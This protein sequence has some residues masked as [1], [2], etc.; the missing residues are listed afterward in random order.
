MASNKEYESIASRTRSKMMYS[1]VNPDAMLQR[2][3]TPHTKDENT[4]PD[5]T[6]KRVYESDSRNDYMY[7]TKNQPRPL[8]LTTRSDGRQYMYDTM[9]Q[10]RQLAW[11]TRSDGRQYMYDTMNQPSQLDLTTRSD[12]RQYQQS[13]KDQ[14]HEKSV[15]EIQE[16]VRKMEEELSFAK[17]RVRRA[18]QNQEQKDEV[19][20]EDSV[21]NVSLNSSSSTSSVQKAKVKEIE[22]AAKMAN[23]R[24]SNE[25]KERKRQLQR[26]LQEVVM[27]QELEAAA[28]RTREELRLSQ[29]R[30]DE[31]KMRQEIE[32]EEERLSCIEL[33]MAV[34]T[35]YEAAIA[36]SRALGN[37]E[38][39]S[40][41]AIIEYSSCIQVD[42]INSIHQA[43]NKDRY[44]TVT[45]PPQYTYATDMHSMP[46]AEDGFM[47]RP[48]T[49]TQGLE[50][51][52]DAIQRQPDTTEEKKPEITK[53]KTSLMKKASASEVPSTA[54]HPSQPP[55]NLTQILSKLAEQQRE[56]SLPKPELD[57]FNGTDI[58]AFPT[59]MRN[60]K[61]VVEDKTNDDIRR[62]ELLLKYTSGEARQLIEQCPMIE[63][64]EA[65]YARA[66]YLL[67]RDYGQSTILAAA[68]RSKAEGWP[69]VAASDKEAL[70]RYSVFL[71]NLCSGKISNPDL[72][73]M[74]QL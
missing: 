27:Q 46:T 10:T 5:E 73:N 29:Q 11:T 21:S 63:P 34:T 15:E 4:P 56:T 67:N 74:R 37:L 1:Q 70:R 13:K 43:R 25:I 2:T 23:I 19:K 3:M 69:R 47:Y 72:R 49:A 38:C 8:D 65:G 12:G 51:T 53:E 36:A 59:F 48:A 62:L 7:D 31:M 22:L 41:V 33:E 52:S 16:A 58:L 71:T 28:C 44:A 45:A 18:Q 50:K 26:R 17:E 57:T 14:T 39:S 68:Y 66:K 40:E 6:S 24:R 20:P 30:A 35:D 60:F 61:F 64:P 55:D 54:P 42:D 32:E 9:N